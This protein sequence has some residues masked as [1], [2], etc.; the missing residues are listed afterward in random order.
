MDATAH[1]DARIA[2][3]QE[4]SMQDHATKAA[5]L[6]HGALHDL[7]NWHAEISELKHRP[8]SE[9]TTADLIR[10]NRLASIVREQV[11]AAQ[12]ATNEAMWISRRQAPGVNPD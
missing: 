1:N 7:A 9:A 3:R 6:L 12:K 4:P 8:P 5:N 10:L 2:A 11:S